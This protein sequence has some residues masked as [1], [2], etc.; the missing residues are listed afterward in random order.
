MDRLRLLVV[1][2][3]CLHVAGPA[4][5]LSLAAGSAFA[6]AGPVAAAS[7]ETCPAGTTNIAQFQW[8]G[9]AWAAQGAASGISVSG[10]TTLARWVRDGGTIAAVVITA[11]TVTINYTYDPRTWNGAIAS[12]DVEAAAGSPLSE[13]DFCSGT[14]VSPTSGSTISVGVTKTA[15]CATI[16]SDG[17]A[18]VSGAITIVRHKPADASPSVAIRIRTTRDNVWANGAWLGETTSIPGLTSVVMAPGTDTITVPYTVS[19]DPGNATA[20]TNKIEIT[21]EQAVSGLDRHKYYSA[22][23]DF[24]VC[25]AATP[26][27]TPSPTPTPTPGGSIGGATPTPTPEEGSVKAAT[28]T[29]KASVPNTAAGSSMG[30][31]GPA[32]I[33]LFGILLAGSGALLASA[34]LLIRR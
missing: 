34:K 12:S 29:P 17:M 2:R 15:T 13:I 33:L 7:P 14:Q 1:R 25:A 22:T 4:L 5:A 20:F 10:D 16:G 24:G 28:P 6:L 8:T 11:G 18:T 19:F 32:P 21:V 9:S 3:L 31:G 30:D 23:A 27:P 26:T